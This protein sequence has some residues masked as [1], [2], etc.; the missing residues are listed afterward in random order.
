MNK[1]LIL[2]L[3]FAL[4]VASCTPK[5]E[6]PEPNGGNPTNLGYTPDDDMTTIPTSTSVGFGNVNLPPA[7]DI[8]PKFPPMGDQGQYGTCVA[9]AVGYNMKTVIEGVEKG[10]NTS[11]LSMPSNQLSPRDL[12]TAIP[13]NQKGQNCN[14]TNFTFALD[15]VQKRGVATMQTVPYTSLGNCNQSSL[16]N[17]WTSD[18]NGH[19]IKSYRKIEPKVNTI[20]EYIYKNIPVVFGARLADNFMTWNSDNV[21]TSNTTYDQTGIH[22]YHAMV[23]GGYDDSKGP[24]GAF[25]VVNSWG[26]SWGSKG[27]IWIDYNFF[28]STFCDGGDGSKPLFIAE[29]GQSD[30]TPPGPNPSAGGVDLAPWVFND[31]SVGGA[32]RVID[33]NVYNI[34]SQ[35]AS[36]SKDWSLYYIY[37]NA[38]DANDYGVITYDD[39]NTSIAT[40]TYVN[41]TDNHAIFNVDIPAGSDMGAVTFG[42]PSLQRQYNMPGISGYYY[43]VL[44]AD[45]TNKFEEPN[46]MNNLFYTTVAPK[47]FQFGYSNK[48]GANDNGFLFENKSKAKP[49]I[50]EIRQSIYSTA[51]TEDNLNAYRPDE[52]ISLLKAKNQSGDLR[53]KIEAFRKSETSDN[54]GFRNIK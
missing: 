27:Y 44:I 54:G 6:K 47:Y 11:Q 23:I 36:S 37:Y 15:V 7:V 10:Y 42:V 25:K 35:A 29:N 13:D 52:I 26:G 9:W 17:S 50:N 33:L 34:G 1:H 21:L 8:V 2:P 53:Q 49:S 22:A 38:F 4:A 46:E 45:A 24:G 28:I 39:F 19:R 14:G 40:N 30:N 51:V 32:T 41:V 20:K 18:A 48:G 12:F 3:L 31:Y 43:L 16:Q 5:E